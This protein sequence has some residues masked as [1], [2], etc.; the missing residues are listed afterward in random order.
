MHNWCA[1]HLLPFVLEHHKLIFGALRDEVTKSHRYGICYQI[2]HPQQD[3]RI[4]AHVGAE[5]GGDDGIRGDDTVDPA[6]NETFYQLSR[7]RGGVLL[8]SRK[9][10]EFVGVDAG[11][12]VSN[13]KR[14]ACAIK[15]SCSRSRVPR[16]VAALVVG[17]WRV[18]GGGGTCRH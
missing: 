1:A 5:D 18:R 2:G 11:L 8:R 6:E 14:V 3:D 16:S 12:D 13:A 7:L 15:V 17:S 9:F 10:T 4:G